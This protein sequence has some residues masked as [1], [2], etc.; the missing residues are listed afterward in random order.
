LHQLSRQEA[1]TRTA[2]WLSRLHLSELS[3]RLPHQL[4]GG[5]QQWA[6]VPQPQLLLMDEPY[7]HMDNKDHNGDP[8]PPVKRKL[9]KNPAGEF[10]LDAVGGTL[11]TDQKVIAQYA[12]LCSL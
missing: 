12:A 5:Q 7:V 3:Q 2:E 11:L 6:L 8:K 4:S 1:Q 10:E 9:R